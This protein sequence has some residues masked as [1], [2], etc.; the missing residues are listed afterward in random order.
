METGRDEDERG[1]RK[2][3]DD[4]HRV[5]QKHKKNAVASGKSAFYTL[6]IQ[7]ILRFPVKTGLIVKRPFAFFFGRE[8]FA[9]KKKGISGLIRLLFEAN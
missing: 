7:K 4:E 9:K 2:G 1:E 5:P 6:K 8:N 3:T